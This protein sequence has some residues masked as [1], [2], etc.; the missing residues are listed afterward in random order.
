MRCFADDSC[1]A[2]FKIHQIKNIYCGIYMV[3]LCVK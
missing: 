2:D 1:W 3:H